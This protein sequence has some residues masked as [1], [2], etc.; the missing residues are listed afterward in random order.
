MNNEKLE[1]KYYEIFV[2][3][4]K[5]YIT[6]DEVYLHIYL[7]EGLINKEEF[8]YWTTRIKND[9]KYCPGMNKKKMINYPREFSRFNKKYKAIIEHYCRGLCSA[10]DMLDAIEVLEKF[11]L[12]SKLW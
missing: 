11:D 6:E 8:D 9:K 7:G 10:Q 12:F 1:K 3:F 4:D 2:S 5:G